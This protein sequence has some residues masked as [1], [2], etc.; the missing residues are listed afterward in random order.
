ML[1]ATEGGVAAPSENS[2]PCGSQQRMQI[3][4]KPSLKDTYGEERPGP[5]GVTEEHLPGPKTLV[6]VRQKTRKRLI[7]QGISRI[8]SGEVRSD[9]VVLWVEFP[10]SAYFGGIFETS[11]S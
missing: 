7:L 11:T 9:V 10:I 6:S 8:S 2:M 1:V 3:A 5:V 4:V